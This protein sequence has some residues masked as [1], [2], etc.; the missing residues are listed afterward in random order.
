MKKMRDM[1]ISAKLITGFL[2]IS[3]VAT[4][5]GG[6]GVFGVLR[7]KTASSNTYALHT[8]PLED[9][10][11][12]VT[13]VYQMRIELRNATIRC[14]DVKQVEIAEQNYNALVD[15]YKQSAERFGKTIQSPDTKKLFDEASK[16]FDESFNPVAGKTFELAKL[17]K[18]KEADAAGATS[19]EQIKKM[20]GNYNQCLSDSLNRV[21]TSNT[22][23]ENLANIIIIV[24]II[25]VVIGLGFAFLLGKYISKIISQPITKMVN[26]ANELAIGNTDI[27]IDVDNN[28]ETGMLAN[29][30]NKMI[31]GIKAQVNIVSAVADGDLTVEVPERSDKDTMGIALN[32][33]IQQI[34]SMFNDIN[35]ASVQVSIGSEQV[36]NGAQAL[37]Q[38]A[39]EQASSIEEL[40]ATI[41]S[42]S[43]QVNQNTENVI[44]ATDYVEQAGAGVIQSN[45]YMKNMLSAMTEINNSSNEISKII[46]VIDDIAFQT[47]IL[48]LN[49]AVE[50]ARAGSAGKGFAVVADE[51]RNLASKS[52]DAAKQTTALIE[53]SIATVNNGAKIAEQTAVSLSTVQSKAMLVSETMEKISRASRVQA[54][55][56]KQINIGIEQISTVVQTNSA[57]AEE[58][59]ASSEE[60]S[61]QANVLK[62][63]I[64]KF[65][66]NQSKKC[67]DVSPIDAIDLD[68][69]NDF[70][71]QNRD[72]EFNKY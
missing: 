15:Q 19:T 3:I 13:N 50:A 25:V 40:S 18:Q 26:A 57:T 70:T 56:I 52:A 41:M 45:D 46:K 23:N 47:N 43:A 58:S 33:T 60:L 30:F 12:I 72:F 49:A 9:I 61:S 22:S 20:I 54:D 63:Q 66:L 71:L 21:N 69:S 16:L 37:S 6:V 28:D 65:K 67:E 59:A 8:R 11:A 53:D 62:Q 24:L 29:S 31:D 39:T 2:I 4:I 32:K 10:F 68:Y 51:V 34:N 36:S 64:A 48:A 1:K 14:S 35:Q 7:M 38:G 42:V 44:L 55:A 5:I 17:G 27:N